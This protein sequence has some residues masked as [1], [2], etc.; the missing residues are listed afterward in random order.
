MKGF[1]NTA[2]TVEE[3]SIDPKIQDILRI[4]KQSG[5]YGLI[6]TIARLTRPTPARQDSLF[7]ESGTLR[8]NQ[9]AAQKVRPAR[10]QPTKAP[11]A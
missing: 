4:V 8:I 10:P 1:A 9:Q 2:L 7:S 5:D 11:E 3:E 6:K